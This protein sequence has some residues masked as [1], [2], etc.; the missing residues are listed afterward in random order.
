MDDSFERL[1]LER[2]AKRSLY[3][4]SEEFERLP[5]YGEVPDEDEEALMD[6]YRERQRKVNDNWQLSQMRAQAGDWYGLVERY[7]VEGDELVLS[8]QATKCKM[9]C[10]IVGEKVTDDGRLSE[11]VRGV[12][13]TLEIETV[14]LGADGKPVEGEGEGAAEESES[15]KV[16]LA[17]ADFRGEN[18][19]QAI[20]NCYTLSF[21]DRSRGTLVHELG[22][23][24]SDLN[25]N[26]RTRIRCSYS[27]AGTAGTGKPDA[28][29]GASAPLGSLRLSQLDIVR[30]R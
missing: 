10:I 16:V 14:E 7:V 28:G 27:L 24:G 1:P 12:D 6:E 29:G 18:G 4:D 22:I 15:T 23:R 13:R 19:N 30:E 9:N 5:N 2:L 17:P 26:L 3:D 8:D 21:V 11:A 25:M 20:A